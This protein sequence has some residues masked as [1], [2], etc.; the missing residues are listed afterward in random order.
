MSTEA[1]I[2][3]NQANSQ[4]STGPKS[5]TGKAAAARNNFR[6]GL[7]PRSEFWVLPCE[8]QTDYFKLLAQFQQEHQPETPTEEALVQAMA[9]HHWLRHR[10][11]RLEEACFD[12]TT[13]Q[14]IDERKLALYLRYQT[15]HERAFHKALNDLLKLRA[16][17]R[18]AEIGFERQEQARATETRRSERHGMKKERHKWEIILAQVKV[19]GQQLR[20]L[21]HDIKE[22]ERLLVEMNRAR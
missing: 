3:A 8:S 17:K 15:T 14:I 11:M 13:G 20:D 7:T 21:S 1:Q 9:E 12:Y 16:E 6:H 18:K 5:E 2:A 19:E 4:L 22:S 10:A